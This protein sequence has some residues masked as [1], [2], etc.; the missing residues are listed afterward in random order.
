MI[1]ASIGAADATTVAE[2]NNAVAAIRATQENILGAQ[3]ALG[4]SIRVARAVSN[5]ALI[6]DMV[7]T[8]P[9]N[10]FASTDGAIS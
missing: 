7:R 3:E 8:T 10:Q 9:L 5:T 4:R 1:K 6:T 2:A